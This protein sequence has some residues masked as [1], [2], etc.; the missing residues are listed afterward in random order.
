VTA[1]TGGDGL[2]DPAPASPGPNGEEYYY[3]YYYYDDEEG[4]E[5]KPVKQKQPRPEAPPA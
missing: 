2:P 1:V 5:Q 3:Y 4:G